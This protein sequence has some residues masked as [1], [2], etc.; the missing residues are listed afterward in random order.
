MRQIH[1][2]VITLGVTVLD[3]D[4]RIAWVSNTVTVAESAGMVDLTV[5]RTGTTNY[6]NTIAYSFTDGT[7][8]KSTDY[9]ATNGVLMV[10]P[11]V[12]TPDLI[13][14]PPEKVLSLFSVAVPV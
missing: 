4:S 3:E 2:E 12:R 10:D 8:K 1:A 11:T 13:V 7:A 9:W 5:Y 6:T 14:T